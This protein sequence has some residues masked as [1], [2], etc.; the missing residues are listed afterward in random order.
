MYDRVLR[1]PHY[2]KVGMYIRLSQEDTDKKYESD[3]ESVLNQRT[4]ITNYIE[5][6][7]FVLVKEYVDDGYSGT[8]FER[9]AFQE[10]LNDISKGI[11]NCV[12]TKDLSR[13]G[14][15][16]IM[17]GYYTETYFNENN[18]RGQM[19]KKNEGIEIEYV[20]V[21]RKNFEK[22][23]KQTNDIFRQ[24]SDNQDE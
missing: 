10:L 1:E 13:L 16:H 19:Y 9:P 15:D 14:R 6:N 4:I 2:Y 12:I 20:N 11:I 7:G 3:S 18:V 22:K 21:A 24:C 8:N 5:T 23:N 17:T